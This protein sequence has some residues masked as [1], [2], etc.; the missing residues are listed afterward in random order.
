MCL[1]VPMKLIEIDG[2]V[3]RA[4]L[5]GVVRDVRLDLLEDAKV[6]DYVIIHAGFAIQQLDQEEAHRT[7]ALLSELL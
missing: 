4:E 3:G 6:G 1:A 7:L 5:G 2:D